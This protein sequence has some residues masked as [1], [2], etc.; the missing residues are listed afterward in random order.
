MT[1]MLTFLEVNGYRVEAPDPEL[2]EW[3]I[4]FSERT[5][6]AARR[7]D[8]RA[9]E[10]DRLVASEN[11]VPKYVPNCPILNRAERNSE[12]VRT[13]DRGSPSFECGIPKPKV[14]GSRP[15]VRFGVSG[16]RVPATR[17]RT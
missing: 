10:A 13:P 4:S 2:A 7:V 17:L 1:A 12:D 8:S 15:V 3:I 14:A 9:S 11:R 16:I 6:R 5:G